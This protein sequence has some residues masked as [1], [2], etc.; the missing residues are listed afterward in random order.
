MAVELIDDRQGE[1][2]AIGA[3][4]RPG[5]DVQVRL[6]VADPLDLLTALQ[7]LQAGP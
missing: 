1:D 6:L 5:E 2:R 3:H 4:V 7:Q